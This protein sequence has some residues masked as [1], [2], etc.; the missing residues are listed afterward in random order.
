MVWRR[1]KIEVKE[2]PLAVG[3]WGFIEISSTGAEADMHKPLRGVL[4]V[5]GQVL[6]YIL[7]YL[8]MYST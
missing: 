4:H 8:S 2:T 7:K 6:R 1:D 5:H 3:S